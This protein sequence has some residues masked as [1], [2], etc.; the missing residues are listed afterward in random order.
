[1]GVGVGVVTD[2]G[3][4]TTGSTQN[5]GEKKQTNCGKLTNGRGA[6]CSGIENV[7]QSE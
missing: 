7:S 4:V 2:G 3:E 5:R 1:M 6:T